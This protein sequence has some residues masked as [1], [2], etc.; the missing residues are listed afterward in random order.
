MYKAVILGCENSHADG[1]LNLIKDDPD[2]SELEIV[3]VYSNEPEAAKKLSETFGVKIMENYDDVVGQVDGVIVTARHGDNHYKYAKPYISS[4]VPFFIDKPITVTEEDALAMAREM[5][6]AKVKVCGGSMCKYGD[7]VQ[8]L[9]KDFEENKDGKTVGGVVRA[10]ISLVNEYGGYYFY[11]QHLVEIMTEIFGR[12]PKAVKAVVADKRITAIFRYEDFDVCAYYFDGNY[13]YYA[14]RM[15]E[16]SDIGYDLSLDN[17]CKR[18]LMSFYQLLHG[19]EPH[20][21]YDEFIAPVFIL[22]ALKRSMETG[23]EETIYYTPV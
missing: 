19:E 9:R 1:F 22:N 14:M 11:S 18:E 3:G 23:A 13:S 17:C 12:F 10:P 4:G 7:G 15:A 16:T 6:E 5:R 8:A 2:F 21:S 20:Q